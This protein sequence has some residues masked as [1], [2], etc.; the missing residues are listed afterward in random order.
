MCLSEKTKYH[1]TKSTKFLGIIID[2]KLKWTEDI[3]YVKNKISKSSG[4][5]FKARNYL[6]KK[7]L[8]QL[9]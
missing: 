6:D 1:F 9:Y 5:L 3:T 8:K 2:N 4:I 7:T